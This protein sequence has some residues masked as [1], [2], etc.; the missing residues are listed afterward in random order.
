M[1]YPVT[2]MFTP[3]GNIILAQALRDH[4]RHLGLAHTWHRMK[5]INVETT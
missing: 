1:L 2:A 4:F 3:Q 5:G